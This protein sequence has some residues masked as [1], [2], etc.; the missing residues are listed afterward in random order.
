MPRGPIISMKAGS[1]ERVTNCIRHPGKIKV[2][3]RIVV[4]IYSYIIILPAVIF[5]PHIS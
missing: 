1:P 2:A 5:A 3:D 4:V